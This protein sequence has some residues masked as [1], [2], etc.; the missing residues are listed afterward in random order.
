MKETT[1]KPIYLGFRPAGSAF[2]NNTSTYEPL[3]GVLK[4]LTIGQDDPDSSS[5]DAEFF[6]VPFDI[7][8]DGQPIT[9]NF[10]LANYGLGGQDIILENLFGGDWDSHLEEYEGADYAYTSEWEWRIEFSRGHKGV[11]IYRGLTIGTIKKDEDG[12]LNFNVTITSLDAK[13]TTGYDNW[14]QIRQVSKNAMYSIIG[15]YKDEDWNWSGEIG[16]ESYVFVKH[17]FHDPQDNGYD[18]ENP[19]IKVEKVAENRISFSL[20]AITGSGNNPSVYAQL[21]THE[22]DNLGHGEIPEIGMP[23]SSGDSFG[24]TLENFLYGRYNHEI[25]FQ[26]EDVIE[27]DYLSDIPTEPTGWYWL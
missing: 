7:F 11:I 10:E 23:F 25:M 5:I 4:G 2:I 21:N 19:I 26:W 18:C 1:V 14:H 9:F 16:D 27:L 13:G 3:M 8:Y 6:D 20:I 24:D 17:Y 22:R 12:A 15:D